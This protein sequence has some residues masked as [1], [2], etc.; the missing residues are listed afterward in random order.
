M[1]EAVSQKTEVS[2]EEK[3]S[4]YKMVEGRHGRFLVNP[5]DLYIG[6]SL[7]EYGEYSPFEWE[8]Y[9]KILV[10]GG[11]VIEAGA[12][13]GSL[14]VPLANTVGPQGKIYAYEPQPII[15]Q[16]MCANLALNGLFNVYAYNGGCAQERGEMIIP[17]ISYNRDDN[18]GGVQ[19]DYFKDCKQGQKIELLVIDEQE[20][21]RVNLFK[22]D[23]EGME[24]QVLKGAEE[25]IKRSNPIIYA[26]CHPDERAVEKL[27]YLYSLDYRVFKHICPLYTKANYFSNPVDI[28]DGQGCLNILCFPKALNVNI[29]L[30]EIVEPKDISIQ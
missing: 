5:H 7:I 10:K 13:S 25:T 28:F 3:T 24:L 19:L 11:V 15:F 21:P 18:Y 1:D 17:D 8:L 22:L 23:V 16:N 20:I 14:T 9:S 30:P 27:E 12:N 2:I 29:N 26:E 4:F 6:R